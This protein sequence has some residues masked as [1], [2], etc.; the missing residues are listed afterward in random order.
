[1]RIRVNTDSS[2]LRILNAIPNSQEIDIYINGNLVFSN[3]RYKEFSP[4]TP[5]APGNYEIEIYK[6]GD[7][8]E[9]IHSHSVTIAGGNAGT[10]VVTGII[11]KLMILA[12][13]ED[14]TEHVAR[15]NAKFRVAHLSPTTSPV[16]VTVNT[17]KMIEEIPFG[18]RTNYAEVPTGVYDFLIEENEFDRI[19]KNNDINIKNK[20]EIKN[21]KIYT[22]YIV[23]DSSNAEIIQSLDL[24]TYINN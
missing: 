21:E 17:V 2:Y 14:P 8:E 22:L 15:G 10:L 11:P 13:F 6:S 18:K 4:Y 12:V 20:I 16:D 23:G 1:M 5:T 24:T 9:V 19:D 3:M 7:R